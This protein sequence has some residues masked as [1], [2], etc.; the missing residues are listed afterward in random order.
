MNLAEDIE[1]QTPRI[2]EEARK[3]VV[4]E[5]CDNQQDRIGPGCARFE[6]LEPVDDE[7]LAQARN[8]DRRRCFG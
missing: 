3:V 4:V 8:P 2:G 7:V 6:N 1:F 5:R